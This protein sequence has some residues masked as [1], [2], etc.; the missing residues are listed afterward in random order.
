[1]SGPTLIM[2]ASNSPCRGIVSIFKEFS[3]PLHTSYQGSPKFD[4]SWDHIKLFLESNIIDVMLNYFNSDIDLLHVHPPNEHIEDSS[5]SDLMKQKGIDVFV[6]NALN[7]EETILNFAHNKNYD[8][9][10]LVPKNRG[11]IRNLFHHSVTN[12]LSMHSDIPLF[13]WK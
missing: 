9:I 7:T 11:I 3:T 2:V 5:Y 1:M 10:T 6:E 4:R 13:I 12:K 8:L